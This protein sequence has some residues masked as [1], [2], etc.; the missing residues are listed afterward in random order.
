MNRTVQIMRM[1]MRDFFTWLYLPWIIVGGNF[2]INLIITL[3]ISAKGN[4]SNGGLLSLFIYFMIIGMITLGQ[5]FPL[6]LG[7]SVRRTD[8][9]WG[10]SAVIGVVGVAS[11]LFITILSA[12]EGHFGGWMGAFYFFNIEFISEH[13]WL[14]EFWFYLALF[15]HLFFLGFVIACINRRVGAYKL[16][17]IL[18]ALFV[19]F[20]VLSLLATYYG[21]WVTLFEGI[22]RMG[23][24]QIMSWFSLLTLVYLGISYKA[25]RRATV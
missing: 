17:L 14:S 1:H 13:G 20:T 21:W 8:Y 9:F 11:A 19:I 7:L 15:L 18:A 2:L 24:I 6:S 3:L 12:I 25:L 16:F 23:P 5:T 10:T 4:S 22:V